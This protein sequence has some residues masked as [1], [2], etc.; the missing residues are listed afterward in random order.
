[1]RITTKQLRRIISEEVENVITE[2]NPNDPRFAGYDD[3][4]GH[5]DNTPMVS[6]KEKRYSLFKLMGIMTTMSVA[7]LG[8]VMKLM[9]YISQNPQKLYDILKSVGLL[10]EGRPK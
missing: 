1:M 9:I 10:E 5:V 3:L 8:S 2:V 7:T 6:N 4:T